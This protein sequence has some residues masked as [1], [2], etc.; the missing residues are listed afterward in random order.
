MLPWIGRYPMRV[1]VPNKLLIGATGVV[2]STLLR[3]VYRETMQRSARVE[4]VF[5]VAFL[6]CA[7]VGTVWSG[8]LAFFLGSTVGDQLSNVGTLGSGIP[9]FAGAPYHAMV[10]LVWSLAY[11]GLSSLRIAPRGQPRRPSVMP[12]SV[13]APALNGDIPSPRELLVRDGKRTIV[14]AVADVDW[15]EADGD[16]V[17]VHTRGKSLLLRDTMTRLESALAAGFLRIHRSA[18]VNVARVSEVT[19]LPN[20]E[21]HVL[22]RGGARLRASR[23]YAERLRQALGIER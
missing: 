3:R 22:L 17:R 1:M 4:L 7:V 23:T 10:L 14:L 9:A 11:I 13:G 6:L 21:F 16:Y 15:I 18:I 20:R 2:A 5:C 19:A 8:V 12:T